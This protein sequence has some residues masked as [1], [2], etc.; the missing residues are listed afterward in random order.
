VLL[1]GA[2]VVLRP[3]RPWEGAR[4]E[5][6]RLRQALG[7]ERWARRTGA[8]PDAASPIARLTWL[9]RTDPATYA[10]IGAVLL[11]HD[12]LTYRMVGRPVTDRG[13]ASCTGLWSPY[14]GTWIGELLELLTTDGNADVWLDRLPEVLEPDARADW[15]D[16]PVYELLGLRGRP[17]VA[18]GTA[19]PMAVA[20][21]LGLSRGRIGIALAERTTVL[22]PLDEPVVDASGAVQS[23]A[24]ATGHHLAVAP[25]P[26]GAR[27]V[28][29]MAELLD[30]HVGDFA[31]VARLAPPSPDELVLVPGSDGR[32]GAVL[33]G[34]GPVA[35]RDEVA[36]ATFEGI[37]C[38]AL[39]AVDAALEAGARWFDHE[40][41]HLTG[42]GDALDV[43]AQVLATLAGRPVV[44][45]PGALAAAGA[46]VQ[47]AAVYRGLQPEEV[48]MEW[49]LGA[50]TEYDP[51]DD[52][53]REH[54]RALHAEEQDRQDRAWSES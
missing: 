35:G 47:A 3:V 43:H 49:D 13:S 6:A 23:R 5:V 44:A 9:G 32:P 40:P 2:G 54:R 53:E 50:G 8:V 51:E 19:E 48:A 27:L 41:L 24:D 38:S 16:A 34:L 45:T 11:P 14:T 52:P 10:R 26:G 12:W 29:A 39:G 1:D 22:A 7:A 37:A 4:A 21:A 33:T 15:L 20:L 17:L 31:S 28:E 30:L 46:C 36:R 18:P 25:A 42:P